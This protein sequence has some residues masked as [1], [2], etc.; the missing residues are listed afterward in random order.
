MTE[1]A[2]EL[3]GMMKRRKV[4]ILSSANQLEVWM[5]LERGACQ[6]GGK[7]V[8]VMGL[9]LEIKDVIFSDVSG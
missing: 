4:D 8:R 6:E 1:K 2:R 5:D 9:K 3:T 7:S